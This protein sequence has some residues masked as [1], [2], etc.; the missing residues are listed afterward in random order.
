MSPSDDLHCCR[1]EPPVWESSVDERGHL[2][3]AELEEAPPSPPVGRREPGEARMPSSPAAQPPPATAST[4]ASASGKLRH[5]LRRR[6]SQRAGRGELSAAGP[7][8]PQR[9]APA[10]PPEEAATPAGEVRVTGGRGWGGGTG[11]GNR[12]HVPVVS[13]DIASVCFFFHPYIQEPLPRISWA[14]DD[15]EVYQG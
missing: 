3:Y 5:L 7:L 2:F 11:Q 10:G 4:S 12:L 14:R 13:T 8:S 6:R 1:S 15:S 9:R